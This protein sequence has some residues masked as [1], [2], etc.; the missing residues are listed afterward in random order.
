MSSFTNA[1]VVYNSQNAIDHR[2]P[3]SSAIHRTSRHVAFSFTSNFK[4]A[5]PKTTKK[6]IHPIMKHEVTS[7]L[8]RPCPAIRES[9][10]PQ[11][12][13]LSASVRSSTDWLMTFFLV[14]RPWMAS[15]TNIVD[16]CG[17][18]WTTKRSPQNIIIS[19]SSKKNNGRSM[20]WNALLCS[21][22]IVVVSPRF[23]ATFS[24]SLSHSRARLAWPTALKTAGNINVGG[25]K[26]TLN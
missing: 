24:Y 12:I 11:L 17:W 16:G 15:Q 20:M 4:K 6:P 21:Q 10:E 25:I 26:P 9:A 23:S 18:G 5:A 3:N 13:P 1:E 14:L 7:C 8:R 2:E 19:F 22:K